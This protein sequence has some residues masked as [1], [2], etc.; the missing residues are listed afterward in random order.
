[1]SIYQR[2]SSREKQPKHHRL[3]LPYPVYLWIPCQTLDLDST[4]LDE[5]RSTMNRL[6]ASF[7]FQGL[8][9]ERYAIPLTIRNWAI[10]SLDFLPQ[11][12]EQ[13]RPLS[14]V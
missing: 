1:M 9:A 6:D 7:E 3:R 14:L 2:L 13:R 12:A 5:Y 4:L 10:G 11:V 8:D